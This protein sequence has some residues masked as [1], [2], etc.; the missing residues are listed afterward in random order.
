MVRFYDFSDDDGDIF[1]TATADANGNYSQ[2][3][4]DGSW[5][6]VT[7]N[8]QGLINK[9]WNNISCSAT[10]DVNSITPI[11][12]AG[13]AVTNINFALTPGGGRIAGTITSSAPGNPPI[14]GALVF[15]ID[16]GGNF[17]FSMAT[18]DSLGHY[19]SDGGTD[20]GNVFVITANGQGFQDESYNN[21]KCTIE[22]C[23]TADPVA[24]TF[25]APK[26]GIDFVLDPGGRISGTVRDVNNAPLANVNVEVHDSNGNNIDEVSTDAS[27]NFITSGLPSGTYYV[28]TKNALGLVD[29][30]WNNLLCARGFCNQTQGTP[31]SVTVG[32]TTSGINFVLPPGYKIS[33]TV[34]AAAGGTPLQGVFVS[35]NNSVG[36]PVGGAITDASGAFTT[37]ALPPGTYYANAFQNGYVSQIYNH[38]SCPTCPITN[39]TPIVVLN[40]AITGIDF[41]LLL[42]TGTGS[43]TGTVTDGFNGNLP[44]G[45]QVQLVTGS[46]GLVATT[47]T[48]SG[49]YTFSNVSPG[50]YYVRTN[51]PA[52]GIP[53][54]NQLYDGVTCLNSCSIFTTVG[55]TRVNVSSGGTTSGINF[56]LQRGGVITGTITAA[57]TNLPL[58]FIGAQ[59]FNSAGVSFGTFNT[60]VSGNYSTGGL[61][62]GTYYV[63]TSNNAGY[64]NQLWQ[65]GSCPQTGCLVTTGT[66]V[67]VTGTATTSG[68]N[69]ALALGGRISGKVTDASNGQALN[70]QVTVFT[71]SGVSLGN[72]NTDASGNYTTS[73]LPPGSYFLRS[74]TGLVFVNNQ[75]LAF[76]DQL[77]D[78]TPCVPFCLNPTAGTPVTVTSGTTTGNVNFGLSR[79][80]SVIGAV[81]DSATGV[82]IPSMGV[83]IYT[84]AGVLAKAAA[85]NAGG[86]YT[87]AGLP[88]GTYYARTSSPNGVFYLDALYKG[89]P[90][91]YGCSV[92]NGTPFTVVSGLETPGVDFALSSGAGGISG[93]ITDKRTG[94]PLPNIFVQIYTASGVFTKTAITNVA[95]SY[96]TAGLAPG[97]YYARTFQ[98][99]PTGHANQLFSGKR[100]SST[101]TVTN[102]TLIMVASGATT[103]GI[104]FALGGLLT[105]GDFDADGK[106]DL[107]WRQMQ[108]GDVSMWMMN[109]ASVSQGPVIAP[110]VPLSWQIV[111]Q[112]DLDGDGFT[113]LVWRNNQN[114]D[115]SVWFMNGASARQ[116][117]VIALG[118]PLNW[119]TV[120]TGDLNGDGTADLLWR[121]VQDGD[122]A[123]WLMNGSNVIEA[124]VIA[125]GVPLSWEI[126][127]VGDLDGDGKDDIVWRN[128]A[129]GD[130]ATWLMNGTTARKSPVIS[131]GVPLSWQ[132]SRLAD[133]DGDGKA[134]I[135]W[136]N[137][138]SGD[139]AAW[140]M[141]GELVKQSPV[142]SLG[143]PTEWQL[144][145]AADLDGDGK[146]DLIWRNTRTGD[147]AAWLMDG[148]A[149]R[150]SQ[151]VAPGV[152]M[153]WQIQD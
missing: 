17:P 114:G 105:K 4:A 142:I 137:L 111:E 84:S 55:A 8:T 123:A 81:I 124:P 91:S 33:G 125:A 48:N 97:T 2:N 12:V 31:V 86:G 1:F 79:G 11:V 53:Y 93:T 110:G 54:I 131:L 103:T 95:G 135:V 132:V 73:G 59:V 5:V 152:S 100:C 9:I 26:D 3:L 140:L 134:D 128:R 116:A 35:L 145:R 106:G 78:G 144:A 150:T 67:V 77:Y 83:Q 88:P 32:S 52:G 57:A 108:T 51:A 62:A 29:Y 147:V 38:L 87:V 63:R 129:N 113:D 121:N 28:G 44:T 92:T 39:G 138:Q 75:Q 107:V 34:T 94:L 27:G 56:T 141:N 127:V 61:P 74:A 46:G 112:G 146:T 120:A 148:A 10:C 70:V 20:T 126:A 96:A 149:V 104:D 71:S 89:M 102:G 122:L 6:A 13:G 47:N 143:L 98:E 7:I 130:V 58:Q 66:P 68:I 153:T 24:V 76:V 19:V 22:T 21:H 60:D 118:V 16:G 119:Q 41:P 151:P 36:G 43:L 69:F 65:G 30:V 133:L 50:S 139:V 18:T 80:G 85:T 82:G 101:C 49:V 14:A 40:H 45:L 64:V 99:I 42:A 25:G 115:L 37:G 72:A 23:D 90:C 15:F 136:R 117:P 109:G